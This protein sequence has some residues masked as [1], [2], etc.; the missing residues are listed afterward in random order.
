M[1]FDTPRHASELAHSHCGAMIGICRIVAASVLL[2]LA[3]T[4]TEVPTSSETPDGH[5]GSWS[6][7]TPYNWAHD[8]SPVRSRYFT[9]FSDAADDGM[10]QQ[11]GAIA[12]QEFAEITLLLQCQ[13][14]SAYIYPPGYSKI[15]IY[16]NRNHAENINWAHWGGFIFTI[17]S[18]DLSGVWYDYTTYTFRH[19]LTHNIEFLIEGREDL[20]TDVWFREGIAVY[21]GTLGS[22]A[23]RTIHTVEELEGWIA[24]NADVSGAGNPIAIRLHSDLPTGADWTDYYRMFELAVRYLLSE[25]GLGTSCSDVTKLLFDLRGGTSFASA[26]ESRFGISITMFHSEF[27]DRMK[28]FL[29]SDTMESARMTARSPARIYVSLDDIRCG[30]GLPFAH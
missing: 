1:L 4:K 15:E 8:G 22:P 9:V 14:S 18:S 23:F 28:V 2:L 10:K 25:N 5:V 7:Y 27:F 3:C 12:D 19:E 16:V 30:G 26:F 13:D 20:R 11:L 21:I 6:V 29:R 17:R 24:Q